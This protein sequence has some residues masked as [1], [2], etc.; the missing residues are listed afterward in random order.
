MALPPFVQ[1]GAVIII[2]DARNS[3]FNGA[4]KINKIAA[5][6]SVL[7]LES[8]Y[9]KNK[10][11]LHIPYNAASMREIRDA[12]VVYD[13]A[14]LPLGSQ[15]KVAGDPDSLRNGDWIVDRIQSGTSIDNA[16]LTLKKLS[17]EFRAAYMTAQFDP[18][19]M[20]V[21]KKEKPKAARVVLATPSRTR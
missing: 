7:S 5:E 13:D 15:I 9:R 18:K 16:R 12:D 6:T 2:E 17:K 11:F 14:F 8:V 1:E 4:W 20:T 19:T 10:A 3:H 21:V